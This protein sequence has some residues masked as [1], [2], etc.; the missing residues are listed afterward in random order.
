MPSGTLETVKERTDIVELIGRNVQLR[1]AGRTFK[2]LCPFHN[3]KSP[4]FVVYP[5]NKSFHCFGCGKSGDAFSYVMQT[6]NV[7]FRDALKQLAERAGVELE[8]RVAQKDPERDRVRERLVD[9]NERAASFFSNALWNSP[10]GAAT[11]A[12]LERRGVDR[13][14]AERFGLGF[15]PDSFDA[16][17]SYFTSREV[18]EQ[19]LIEAGLLSTRDDGRSWDRFRNRLTFPIRDREGRTVGFGA[20]ALGDEKPKYLNT[21]QTAI[22]DKR[23]LLYGLDKAHDDIRRQRAVIIVEGYMDAIA[24]Q[25]FGFEN[26]VASMG[27]AVTPTQVSSI[28]RYV[29]RV[30]LALDADAAG[31]MATLRGI[32]ALRDSFADEERVEVKPQNPVRWERTIG[33]EIRIVEIPHGKDPDELIRHDVDAW[34]A[35]LDGATPLVAYYLTHALTDVQPTPMAR[36]KALT[37][38]AVPILREIGDAAVLAQYVGMTS[39]LLGFKDTDVHSAVLRGVSRRPE[40]RLA[41][42]RL[43][44]RPAVS[45]PERYLVSLVLRSPW[46]AYPRLEEIDLD[47][48]L[49]TRNRELIAL[50]EAAEGDA[51]T[52]EASLS[53]EL[54]EYSTALLGSFTRP[55]ETPGITNRDIGTAIRRLAQVRHQFR[56]KQVQSDIELARRAGD[57]E[58]LAEQV[59]RMMLLAQRKPQFDPNESPYFK[60]TRSLAS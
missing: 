39:R 35:A 9:L 43:D 30:Y 47:D 25:Q 37:E 26:V 5:D 27:T 8:S 59:R 36:A 60:D 2:G 12:L 41:P 56:L 10:A 31:Q 44:E 53:P 7:D 1:Q 11:R 38:I 20:R 50:V 19:G 18:G 15:A 29:D 3:E 48:V 42:P 16:L 46:V 23:S 51:E 45:D 22:F 57:Q 14:T 55:G 4:S 49:D 40:G 34:R 6:E 21:A 52:L 13:R 32:D 54:Q 17:K 28:R 24:A 33:A 58:E